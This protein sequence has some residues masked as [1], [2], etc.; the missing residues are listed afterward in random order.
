MFKVEMSSGDHDLEFADDISFS[1]LHPKEAAR[2]EAE[3]R[4][5]SLDL[6]LN[7]LTLD[8]LSEELDKRI[9]ETQRLQEE[10]EMETREA[11][12]K[13]GCTSRSGLSAQTLRHADDSSEG[14]GV[15]S[16]HQQPLTHPSHQEGVL[17]EGC[18]FGM[19]EVDE[20][21]QQLSALNKF[22]FSPEVEKERKSPQRE[23]MKLQE[24]LH[25]AQI[26]NDFLSDLRLKDSRKHVDQMETMLQMLEE[27]QSIKRSADRELQQSE[28]EATPLHRKVEALERTMKEVCE[29]LWEEPNRTQQNLREDGTDRLEDGLPKKP[30]S[31]VQRGL[32]KR[33]R[34]PELISSLGQEVALLTHR[35][36]SSKDS[37]LRLSIRMEQLKKLAERQ[38]SLHR[39]QVR[40]LEAALSFFREKVCFLEQRLSETRL[41]R[42]GSQTER[43]G[44]LQSLEGLQAQL[45]RLKLQTLEFQVWKEQLEVTRKQE[46]KTS[47]QLRL[48][49]RSREANRSQELLQKKYQ[50]LQVLLQETQQTLQAERE[51]LRLEDEKKS[52]NDLKLQMETAEHSH[53]V[54]KLQQENSLFTKQL[55]QQKLQI[56]QLR[57]ELLQQKSELAAAERESRRLQSQRTQEETLEQLQLQSRT[58]ELHSWK[59]D[60]HAR[61]V[62][63]LQ[64]QL[65][66]AREELEK[67]RHN[68][69]TLEG[70][71]RQGLQAAFSMQ[72]EVTSRRE[73]VDALQSRV[74]RLEEE[75]DNL[76][77]EKRLQQLELQRQLRKVS[78]FEE[79]RRQLQEELR[80]LRSRDQQLKGRVG[81]LEATLHK[82]LE[83]FTS[84]R[85]FLQARE[86]DYI[87]LK[88]QH[89][90]DLKELQGR[91]LTTP[92]SNVDSATSPA[93]AAPPSTLR[94]SNSQNQ[95]IRQQQSCSCELRC[96]AGDPHGGASETCRAPRER[97]GAGSCSCRRRENTSTHKQE[98]NFGSKLRRKTFCSDLHLLQTSKLKQIKLD[99]SQTCKRG[100]WL[101]SGGSEIIWVLDQRRCFY[102]F[103]GSAGT[104]IWSILEELERLRHLASSV[105]RSNTGQQVLPSSSPEMETF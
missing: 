24:K 2:A 30:E 82:M 73:Q 63:Q 53:S 58:K 6:G 32:H 42:L 20:N 55:Q 77:Q 4:S 33:E 76:L 54:E 38:T 65:R 5:A 105:W 43:T 91:Y 39:R 59:K 69:K 19:D 99:Q 34:I 83:S 40:D 48:E 13:F 8:E 78:V 103:R 85:D 101:E 61:V 96:S 84:C 21:L 28:E 35:L 15:P 10:M 62:L 45:G 3:T 102:S 75:V 50:E 88:L 70:A 16:A 37:S 18:S 17:K 74:R 93:D 12:E 87:R 98:V 71:E 86:Q 80:S 22:A 66:S 11:L 60:E 14:S 95:P 41:Q 89:A 92:P 23:M 79:E 26:E 1:E 7:C 46:E 81:D 31:E 29:S 47:L 44:T 49:Q 90:L 100:G 9:K 67:T 52:R 94:A 64:S 68:L 104:R 72:T 97:G 57:V 27:V 25:E 56:Q 36:S 51:A